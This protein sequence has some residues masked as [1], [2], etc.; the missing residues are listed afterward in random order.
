MGFKGYRPVLDGWGRERALIGH[1]RDS[2]RRWFQRTLPRIGTVRAL[3]A[4]PRA[5]AIK[6]RDCIDQTSWW[7]QCALVVPFGFRLKPCPPHS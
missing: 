7:H 2:T 3:F 5:A 1:G 4:E 6:P